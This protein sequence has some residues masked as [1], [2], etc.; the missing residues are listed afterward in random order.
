[1]R[2]VPKPHEAFREYL[3]LFSDSD[4]LLKVLA[5][6]GNIDTA[7]DGTELRGHYDSLKDQLDASYGFPTTDVDRLK[8]GSLWNEPQDFMM[9]LLKH[10]RTLECFWLASD[11]V[12]IKDS[13][14]A[15]QLSAGALDDS[16]GF[17]TLGYEFSGWDAYADRLKAKEGSVL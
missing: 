5:F 1:L 14:A 17:V 13:I 7:R 10:D 11:K 3:L 15:I 2:T 16:T 12:A 8:G 6:S 4:G 9:G